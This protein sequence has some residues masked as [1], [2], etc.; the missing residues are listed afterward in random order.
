MNLQEY[1]FA[2]EPPPEI[3]KIRSAALRYGTET[4]V[5]YGH[6]EAF[7]K[8]RTAHPNWELESAMQNIDLIEGFM[9]T[10]DKFVDRAEARKIAEHADQLDPRFS[11]QNGP[12][13]SGEL[14]SEDLLQ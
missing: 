9:T 2:N 10:T 4:F 8:L 14:H 12:L 5:G 1:S 11:A 7:D 3:E 13:H 6:G